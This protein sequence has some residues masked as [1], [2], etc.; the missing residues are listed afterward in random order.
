MCGRKRK[1]GVLFLHLIDQH[2]DENK[3]AKINVWVK[4]YNI[5]KNPNDFINAGY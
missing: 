5:A 1:Q 4:N 2:L 3:R